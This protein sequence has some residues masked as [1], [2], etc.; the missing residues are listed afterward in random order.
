MTRAAAPR[1]PGPLD[2]PRF[3][4]AQCDALFAAV[5]VNDV[6]DAE[7]RLPGEAYAAPD[8]T[9]L[10]DCYRL[11]RQLWQ[12]AAERTAL[13][14]IGRRL[15]RHGTLDAD[16]QVV[17]KNIRAK[18]KQLR[19]TYATCGAAHVY[20]RTFHWLAAVMGSLQDAFKNHR[21]PATLGY[22]LVL[23]CMLSGGIYRRVVREVDAFVPTT[24]SAFASYVEREMDHVK[25]AL[26]RETI[27]GR[28]FHE[29]RKIFSRQTAL[30]CA[31]TILRPAPA[32]TALFRYLA[33]VN[34]MMGQF[35]DGLV[36]KDLRRTQDYHT[37]TF[38]MPPA[39]RERL[40]ALVAW[41]G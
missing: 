7:A 20:P 8:R 1:V 4:R 34:G 10:L 37:G 30:Y 24:A 27:T 28:E 33:S 36:E 22:A 2:T 32:H 12:D 38:A 5:L 26:A 11:S 41:F 35:H 6:V 14:D 40:V 3:T 9:A 19:A 17:F 25:A 18:Y 23:R 16:T 13:L 15:R 31:L 39:I 21:R 29:L